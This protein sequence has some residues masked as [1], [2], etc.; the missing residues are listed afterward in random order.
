M[1][2]AQVSWPPPTTEVRRYR[3]II[4][5]GAC[6][7]RCTY[8]ETK[9]ARVDIAATIASLDKIFDRFDPELVFVRVECDGELTLYPKLLDHLEMRARAGFA[10]EVLSNGTRLPACAEGR[11]HLLW[12]ISLDG[13][14]AAM[15]ARRGLDQAQV[16]RI[17]GSVID[18]N[19]ELQCVYHGQSIDE[20]NAFIDLLTQRSYKGLLHIFPLL[21]LNGRPLEHYLDHDQLHEAPFLPGEEY[22][23][24]WRY[25]FDHGHRGSF[26]CDQIVNGYNYHV[27]NATIS[28]LKCDCYAPPR[29][30]YHPFGSEREYDGFPCGTCLSHQEFNNSRPRMR[31]KRGLPVL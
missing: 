3:N 1:N 24:R 19:A 8:C 22:F 18:R 4:I 16:D 14:T 9:D 12:V 31:I 25:I 20:M 30:M 21:A 26:V 15:N 29:S 7:L 6:N 17:L 23:R 5:S 13:H 27:A 10:I 2:R 28:M 11:D